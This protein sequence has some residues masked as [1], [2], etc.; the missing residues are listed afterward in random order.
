MASFEVPGALAR[1]QARPSSGYLSPLDRWK[2]IG[3]SGWTDT[4]SCGVT[5]KAERPGERHRDVGLVDQDDRPVLAVLGH[6]V[7]GRQR[8][9]EAACPSCRAAIVTGARVE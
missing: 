6:R 5:S 9:I 4:R 1:R 3:T 7:E 2:R 8:V